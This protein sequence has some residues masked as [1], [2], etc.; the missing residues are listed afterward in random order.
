MSLRI[1]TRKP[2][3][4]K[5]NNNE[6]IKIPCSIHGEKH[7]DVILDKEL[8]DSLYKYQEVNSVFAYLACKGFL[9]E[10]V[11]TNLTSIITDCDKVFIKYNLSKWDIRANYN[12]NESKVI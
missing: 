11:K 9:N 3:K 6:K 12:F 1:L 2:K 7:T 4:R 5:K 8:V 10:E